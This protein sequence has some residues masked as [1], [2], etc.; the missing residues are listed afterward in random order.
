METSYFSHCWGV[1]EGGGV[2]GAAHAGAF[3]AAKDSGVQFE[4]LAGTS[5][6]SIVASLI[7]AGGSSEHISKIL[8][9]TDLESLLE[10]AKKEDAIYKNDNTIVALTKYIPV[11]KLK[12]IKDILFYSGM[13]SSSKL[14]NWIENELMKLIEPYRE[15]GTTG[16]VKFKEL[17][18]PLHLVATNLSTGLPQVWSV[19]TTPEESVSYAVRCSCSI[20]FFFQAICDKESILVDG[21]VV[22]NLPSFVFS[23]LLEEMSSYTKRPNIINFR[24]VQKNLNIQKPNNIIEYFEK[25]SNAVVSGG[26]EVQKILQTSTYNILIDTGNI[27]SIDFALMNSESKNKLF[28][29]GQSAMNDFIAS[30]KALIKEGILNTVSQG[31]D[32]KM[33]L[34]IQ[35]IRDCSDNFIFSGISCAWL[36]FLFP[37]I[38]MALK[39]GVKIKCLTTIEQ[40]NDEERF[41]HLLCN[42]GIEVIFLK[43]LPFNGFFFSPKEDHSIAILT[44]TKDSH[45]KYK[46]EKVKLY[47]YYSD[48]PLIDLLREKMD[49]L[50]LE[51]STKENK[52]TYVQCSDVEFFNKL[53]NVRQY[54]N[55]KFSIERIEV[56]DKIYTMSD[57]VKE[58]KV[59]QIKNFMDDIS[60]SGKDIQEIHK[61]VLEDGVTSIIT[62]PILEKIHDKY[63][64]I[65]GNARLF[66]FYNKG[67]KTIKVVIVDDVHDPL[68]SQRANPLSKLRITSLTQTFSQNYPQS[69]KSKFRYIEKAIHPYPSEE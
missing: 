24:L 25:L 32:E 19:E 27:G 15:K 12:P 8:I 46:D 68:P 23:K 2:R 45:D 56:N 36:D 66:H 14:Q 1:F 58:Y 50:W 28:Q 54:K 33:I 67:L 3:K 34:L 65:E 41:H 29:S 16:N 63:Y 53:K 43:K 59:S 52:F 60:N 5:A 22:S 10:P 64:V 9:E 51:V 62:P 31:F 47:S 20:P 37:T 4:R 18:I 6:G 11:R 7:A 39:K 49:P 30:E 44:T 69:D 38:F 55:A 21:G 61:V 57:S 40:G 35:Q 26:T 17:K 42:L 48:A 13:H